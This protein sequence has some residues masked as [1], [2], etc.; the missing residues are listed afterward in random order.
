MRLESRLTLLTGGARDLPDRQQTLRNTIDW[1]YD[2]L[3]P[4]EQVL[5]RRMSVFSG[6]RTL[7]A[8]EAVCNPDTD[9]F[10]DTLDGVES[11]LNKSLVQQLEEVGQEPRFWMLETIHEYARE[12]LEE[13]KEA[14]CCRRHAE[15]FTKLAEKAYYA[16]PEQVKW[17]H[18]EH[19]NLR[20][21]LRWA[22]DSKDVQVGLRMSGAL[23]QFWH[24]GVFIARGKSG[25]RSFYRKASLTKVAKPS[26]SPV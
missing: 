7:S 26:H 23:W 13:G 16:N 3:N 12:K 22:R 15:Y 8:I 19:D 11:L 5:F 4:S 9:L 25:W 6:G 17:L 2:L 18:Q 21:A 14:A 10:V 20:A 1:S 24:Y